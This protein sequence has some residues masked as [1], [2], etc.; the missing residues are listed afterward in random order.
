MKL[1]LVSLDKIKTS[2]CV[3]VLLVFGFRAMCSPADFV[4]A[5]HFTAPTNF[6]G[7]IVIHPRTDPG[8]NPLSL[9]GPE[10]LS[11]VKYGK[12]GGQISFQLGMIGAYVGAG[13]VVHFMPVTPPFLK[14]ELEDRFKNVSGDKTAVTIDTIDGYTAAHLSISRSPGASPRFLHFCWIQVLTNIAIKVTA[15]SSDAD[16]FK[17]ITNSLQTLK[18]DREHFLYALNLKP[19][20]AE[21]VTNHLELVEVGHIQRDDHVLGVC[22]F[23]AKEKLYSFILG[24]TGDP[25]RD[26]KEPEKYFEKLRDLSSVANALKVV[27]LDFSPEQT[28][29]IIGAETNA[30]TIAR[31][32]IGD[33]R[34]PDLHFY[35]PSVSIIWQFFENQI[36]EGFRMETEY[37]MKA[38][39]YLRRKVSE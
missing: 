7:N 19:K 38:T 4:N 30:M 14:E 15:I 33:F 10:F 21:V 17:L 28:T 9:E 29:L 3:V 23:H 11:Y 16:S 13:K 36:P 35:M 37:K 1:S 31:F 20:D 24:E 25:D 22:V 6:H 39:L 26:V 2:L 27:V 32:Q 5:I 12:D 8:D 18:I 34:S